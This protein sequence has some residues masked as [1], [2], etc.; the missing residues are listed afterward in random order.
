MTIFVGLQILE[1]LCANF[2]GLTKIVF[3]TESL[4]AKLFAYITKLPD[5]FGHSLIYVWATVKQS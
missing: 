4:R 1:N 3:S 5:V 2:N